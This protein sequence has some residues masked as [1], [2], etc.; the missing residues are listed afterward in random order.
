MWQSQQINLKMAC[1]IVLASFFKMHCFL[2]FAFFAVSSNHSLGSSLVN[3]LY[4]GH[5]PGVVLRHKMPVDACEILF[6]VSC[7]RVSLGI[8]SLVSWV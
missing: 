3:I 1:N 2:F 7:H 6:K 8:S 4:T 5:F